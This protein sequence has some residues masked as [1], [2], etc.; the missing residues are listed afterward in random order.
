MQ[1]DPSLPTGV[2]PGF[3]H[4]NQTASYVAGLE[5]ELEMAR[6]GND[7]ASPR[8]NPGVAQGGARRGRRSPGAPVCLGG[9]RRC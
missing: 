1:E 3:A 7:K 8:G 4:P 2:P 6:A 5:R 9:R